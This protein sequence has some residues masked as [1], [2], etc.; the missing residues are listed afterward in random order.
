MGD[1]DENDAVDSAPVASSPERA[2]RLRELVVTHHAFVWRSLVRLGVPKA[3]AE[4]ALQQVMM[5]AARRLDDITPGAERSFLYGVSLRVASRTRRT[6]AR[7]REVVDDAVGAERVDE[8]A[9]PDELV[10]RAR[11]RALLDEILES[12]P[13]ELRSA[14]TLFELE[15]LTMIQIAELLGVPQGT[16]A[17]RLRR[18]REVFAEQRKRIEVKLRFQEV[19]RG[20]SGP[21]RSKETP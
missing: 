21:E 11:A 18:A 17:S 16:V 13:L 1:A 5:V 4:D 9:R 7:R 20:K 12:M 15:Q 10:D 19:S 2:A 8:S 6:H 14:F 3:D